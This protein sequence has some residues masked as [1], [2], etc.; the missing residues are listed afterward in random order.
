MI[1]NLFF[2]F[3]HGNKSKFSC[4]G[5]RLC[6][7]WFKERGHTEITVFVPNWRKE[8]SRWDSNISDQEILLELEREKLLVFTPSRTCS[9]KR[10]VSYDDRYIL[11]EAISSGGVIVS[12]DNYRDLAAENAEFRK[13]VEESLLMYS[14]VN[15]K[16]V[17]PDDP[18]GR[19]GPTLD[20]FL[21]VETHLRKTL[22]GCLSSGNKEVKPCPY[23]RK[24]TYGNKCKYMHPE[25][26]TAPVKSVTERLQE[27]AQKH[28][29][30]KAKSR[31]S[32]PGKY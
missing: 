5:L 25:R 18:L 29:Q 27:H 21:R 6:V 32:S 4:K 23:G 10:I 31:D 8:A 13:V 17:P 11:K 24:C 30:D 20:S 16:F 22:T 12:N 1:N 14:W 19:N 15:G 28:F 26:G 3:S 7:E 2:Y 9:G